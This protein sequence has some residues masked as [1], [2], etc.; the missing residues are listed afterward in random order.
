MS[1]AHPARRTLR[2]AAT[3]ACLMLVPTVAAAAPSGV[4]G[5]AGAAGA[6][7]TQLQPGVHEFSVEIDGHARTG[8][9]LLPES[10][11][12]RSDLPLVLN[13]HGSRSD[14]AEQLVWSDAAQLAEEEGYV[15]VLPD[16]GI[17]NPGDGWL[18]NV[19]GVTDAPAGSPDDV[20]FLRSLVE[21]ASDEYG[22]SAENVFATGYSGGGRMISQAAC[23]DPTLFR[24]IAPVTG[25]RAGFPVQDGTGAWVPDPASCAPEE[26]TP[27]VTFVGTE[28]P[29]NPLDGGGA[30]YWRYGHEAALARWA[31]IGGYTS[32]EVSEPAPGVTLTAIGDGSGR[33]EIE[34]WSIEGAGHVWPGSPA[35]EHETSWAGTPTFAVNANEVIWD[36]FEEH[37]VDARGKGNGDGNGHRPGTPGHGDGRPGN[38]VGH[39][40]GPGAR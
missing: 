5:A 17:E 15:V 26:V 3:V 18:W 34:S 6:A 29:V 27:I 20:A 19:P 4:A 16:G 1:T 38:G 28:D 36:F 35:F 32:V 25:L 37:S 8:V 13:L 21:W 31:E 2:T 40:Y 7:G 39:A 11:T 24:A 22:T 30:A 10:W 33:N 23:E 12:P 9:V 14:G